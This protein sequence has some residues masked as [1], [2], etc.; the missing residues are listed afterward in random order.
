MGN[1][2]I[3]GGY[4]DLQFAQYFVEDN[5]KFNQRYIIVEDNKS[6]GLVLQPSTFTLKSCLE[7]FSSDNYVEIHTVIA[8]EVRSFKV[9]ISL[10]T[11]KD[12]L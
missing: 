5:T 2:Q 10:Y 11:N 6:Y 3:E 12:V 4:F 1:L 7:K 8:N 9:V